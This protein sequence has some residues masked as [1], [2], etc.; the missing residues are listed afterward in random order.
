MLSLST[1][2]VHADQVTEPL[3][4]V[5]IHG[6]ADLQD[7]SRLA[8]LGPFG[9]RDVQ[10]V[11]YSLS[12]IPSE[13]FFS[14]QRKTIADALRYL[15]SVQADAG[16]LALRGVQGSVIENTRLD[17]F[18]VVGTTDYPLEEFERIEVL[19]SMAGSLYGP[20]D[21]SGTFNF[22]Q[23]R[24]P[25]DPSLM[26]RAG[27]TE[28]GAVLGNADFGG[29][30]VSD[31]SLR[32]RANLLLDHGNAFVDDSLLRRALVALSLDKDFAEGTS[33]YL[34]FSKYLFLQRGLPG[35]FSVATN[36]PFPSPVDPKRIGY[37]Q[38][39]AGNNNAT[40]IGSI[41]V[42]HHFNSHWTL[43]GG[44]LRQIADR[45][46]SVVTNTLTDAAGAYTTTGVSSGASRFTVNSN[47]LRLNGSFET[48]VL[49]H[50]LALATVGYNWANYN[51]RAGVA[52]LV[53][54]SA[55]LSNPVIFPE[56]T[57]P[58]YTNRYRTALQRAQSLIVADSIGLGKSWDLMASAAYSWLYAYTYN[59]AA[60]T[61]RASRDADISPGVSLTWHPTNASSVYASYADTLQPGDIAPANTANQNEVLPAYRSKEYEAGYKQRFASIDLTAAVFEIRRP[62]AFA[63][64]ATLVDGLPVFRTA[65]LQRNRGVELN[66]VGSVTELVSIYA[67]LAYL[68]PRILDSSNAASDGK[69]IVGLS[70]FSTSVTVDVRIPAVPGLSANARVVAVDRRPADNA[71]TDYISGYWVGDI[72]LALERKIWGW[73]SAFRL[74]VYN[75]T[76]ERYWTNV[77]PGGLGGYSGVGNASANVGAPR[78][79]MASWTMNF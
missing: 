32:G 77:V 57:Y 50:D 28:Q 55:S 76:G 33:V 27:V 70:H 74:S 46:F 37:G 17:G 60:V 58:D 48:G 20:A 49:K 61:T 34:N 63:D 64:P 78:T 6:V 67:G 25:R 69:R 3:E 75:V 14:E 52:S 5:V 38:P 65:G 68:D 16:R 39:Y 54:G 40:T 71:N 4:S 29:S 13:L 10:D 35:V 45:Q 11:P 12:V 18:N 42:E 30:L 2:M 41:R 1:S 72:G 43:S 19:D 47:Q 15:P 59:L 79:A 26:L 21:A 62:Y 44:F 56:P 9:T 53:L 51:P 8:T 36:V 31:G 24:A 22:V 23:K 73:P 66:G 7:E